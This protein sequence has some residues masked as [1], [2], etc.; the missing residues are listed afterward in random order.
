MDRLPRR[1]ADQF[2]RSRIVSVGPVL[3]PRV[4]QPVA[5]RDSSQVERRRLPRGVAVVLDDARGDGRHVVARVRLAR[6]EQLVPEELG[7][8]V[9]EFQ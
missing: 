5:D 4:R 1:R 9:E 2:F 8:R 3:D 6:D 7:L